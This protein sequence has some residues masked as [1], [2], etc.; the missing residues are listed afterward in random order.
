MENVAFWIAITKKT[1]R[2]IL[3]Q[4]RIG[5]NAA[6]T[7]LHDGVDELRSEQEIREENNRE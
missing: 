7:A 2:K 1:D 6:I 3:T 5:R 4:I